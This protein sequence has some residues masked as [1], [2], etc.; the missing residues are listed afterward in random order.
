EFGKR[1]RRKG[2]S[3]E[4]LDMPREVAQLAGFVDQAGLFLADF[5]V[6]NKLHLLSLPGFFSLLDASWNSA[7]PNST[8]DWPSARNPPFQTS[9]LDDEFEGVAL[10]PDMAGPEIAADDTH[11]TV[12][13]ASAQ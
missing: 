1:R 3:D 13:Q 5:P 11:G 2:V 7:P 4:V 8:A 10:A 9:A 12:R 6:T